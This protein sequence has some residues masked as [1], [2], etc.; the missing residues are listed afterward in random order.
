MTDEQQ[1]AAPER[2]ISIKNLYLKDSSYEA[3]NTPEIFNTQTAPE[4]EM[5]IGVHSR[6]VGGNDFEAVVSVTVTAKFGDQTGF[7][8]EVQQAGVFEI[9]GFG[10]DEIAPVLGIYCPNILFPYAREAVSNFVSK[11]GF[12]Q[13]M[14]EPVNFEAMFAAHMEEQGQAH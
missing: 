14:L 2:N 1:G 10:N 8:V 4:V 3:P 7:L 13:L 12:P 9:N 11:G 5:D 6:N